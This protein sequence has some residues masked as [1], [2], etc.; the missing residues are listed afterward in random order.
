MLPPVP[1]ERRTLGDRAARAVFTGEIMR[2]WELAVRQYA[3]QWFHFVPIWA[4]AEGK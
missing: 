1:Y 4:A 3:D 2:V